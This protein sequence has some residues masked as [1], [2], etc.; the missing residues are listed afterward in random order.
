MELTLH[1]ALVHLQILKCPTVQIWFTC[2]KKIKTCSQRFRLERIHCVA[3]V[4][5]PGLQNKDT[6]L[7]K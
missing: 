4:T 5:P 3:M 6:I 2:T 1:P 7:K